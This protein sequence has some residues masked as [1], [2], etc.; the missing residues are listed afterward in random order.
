MMH[1]LMLLIIEMSGKDRT[2]LRLIVQT[3]PAG[4]A[5]DSCGN[6]KHPSAP[7]CFLSLGAHASTRLLKP[8]HLLAQRLPALRLATFCTGT[9]HVWRGFFQGICIKY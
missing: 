4:L 8:G 7:Q 9:V 2:P 3:E 1:I 5:I 6:G